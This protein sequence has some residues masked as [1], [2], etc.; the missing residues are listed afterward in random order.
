VGVTAVLSLIFIVMAYPLFSRKF[1]F[2]V[3]V[4]I[5]AGCVLFIWFNYFIRAYI[6]TSW[7]KGEDNKNKVE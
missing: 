6:F 5:T 3:S 7:K 1:G 4:L 2:P